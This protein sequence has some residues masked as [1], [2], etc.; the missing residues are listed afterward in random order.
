MQL[1]ETLIKCFPCEIRRHEVPF[2]CEFLH[3]H[4]EQSKEILI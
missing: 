2:Y 4:A 1:R 3:I